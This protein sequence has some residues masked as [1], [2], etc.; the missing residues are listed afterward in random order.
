[1]RGKWVCK[2]HPKKTAQQSVQ[3]TCASCGKPWES[4]DEGGNKDVCAYCGTCNQRGG[5]PA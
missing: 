5:D 4:W 2:D 3:R 1:V